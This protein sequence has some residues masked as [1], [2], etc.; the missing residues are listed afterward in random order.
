MK[1]LYSL[2][3][4]ILVKAINPD[5]INCLN[6]QILGAN[7]ACIDVCNNNNINYITDI[8]CTEY[9]KCDNSQR[10]I[11]KDNICYCEDYIDCNEYLCTS[12]TEINTESPLIE[13]TTYELSLLLNGDA[14]NIYVLFGDNINSMHIPEAFQVNQLAGVNIGGINDIILKRIDDSKYD[15]W[16][17]IQ[18]T[19]G[20]IMGRLSTIGIDYSKWTATEPLTINN[21]AIFL[22]DPYLKLSDTDKYVIAHLTLS[23]YKSHK[24]VVN[25][26]GKTDLTLFKGQQVNANSNFQVYNITFNINKKNNINMDGH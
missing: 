20:D 8:D 22:E 12:I 7:I 2:L 3:N 17:T 9:T 18:I 10:L 1:L 24:F 21:G 19:D 4:L 13:Y 11:K 6:R 5:C 15:S 16:F 23:D 25:V 14:K 26:Q